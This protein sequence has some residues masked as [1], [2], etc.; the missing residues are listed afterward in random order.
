MYDMGR[1]SEKFKYNNFYLRRNI[2]ALVFAIK[3]SYC[4]LFNLF[5]STDKSFHLFKR[6]FEKIFIIYLNILKK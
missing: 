5:S 6:Y 3:I 4:S 1:H 2:L